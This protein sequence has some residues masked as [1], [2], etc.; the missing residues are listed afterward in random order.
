MERQCRSPGRPSQEQGVTH[1]RGAPRAPS[2]ARWYSSRAFAP[3][4]LNSPVRESSRFVSALFA[5]EPP[6][7][8]ALRAAARWCERRGHAAPKRRRICAR[9]GHD[10]VGVGRNR[11][12]IPAA[13]R[14]QVDCDNAHGLA[15]LAHRA[16]LRAPGRKRKSALRHHRRHQAPGNAAV[17]IEATRARRCCG[18]A[19][20]RS[21]AGGV[22]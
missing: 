21:A 4:A 10:A 6:G 13:R 22:P 11:E 14:A 15:A 12:G 2:N 9:L 17:A 16:V 19:A 7:S 1:Q 18:G 20:R 5:P 8:C 3:K